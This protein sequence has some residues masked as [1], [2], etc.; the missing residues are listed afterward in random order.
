MRI[1][2]AYILLFFFCGCAPHAKK[3]SKDQNSASAFKNPTDSAKLR[4]ENKFNEF[5]LK[6]NPS[7]IDLSEDMNNELKTFNLKL[8]FDHAELHTKQR[9]I[10]IIFLKQYLFQLQN[11]NQSYDIITM[12]KGETKFIVDEFMELYQVPPHQ[13]WVGSSLIVKIVKKDN[14]LSDD[15]IIDQYLVK[16]NQE[17]K[18][19][20]SGAPWKNKH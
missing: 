1:L 3:N 14:L 15:P 5:V 8:I 18:R 4:Y 20:E 17:E 13:E 10:A 9:W 2:F 19:I 16:I 11:A 6:Y 7:H 12:G